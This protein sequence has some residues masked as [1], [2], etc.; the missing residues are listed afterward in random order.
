MAQKILQKVIIFEEAVNEVIEKTQYV[1]QLLSEIKECET[2]AINERLKE[3]QK[4]IGDFDLGDFSNLAQ[5]VAELN[6][7]IEA[8]LV[9]RLEDL[10]MQWTEEFSDFQAKGGNM[11]RGK[12]VLDI[13]L[14]NYTII[15]EP[16]LA[17]ARAYWYKQLHNQVEVICGLERVDTT[18]SNL[19]ASEKSYKNLLLKMGEK[20]NIRQAYDTLEKVFGDA[21]SYFDTWKSYQAL[22]DIDL[23]KVFSQLSDNIDNWNQLL[24][25]IR[26]GRKIFDS[27][28]DF[29]C[30]GGLEI[31]YNNVSSKVSNKYDQLHKE[32]LS[33]FG[34][35]LAV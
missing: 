20:F 2:D 10:L 26:Q 33:K 34:S 9:R 21:I 17:E 12:M 25:Q 14:Q 11:I 28:E 23:D 1:D 32:I 31:T 3:I 13:K 8:I 6:I 19:T 5:W 4:V 35:T 27:N 22:W 30:F 15:L 29:K 18:R 24:K 7:R 16:T